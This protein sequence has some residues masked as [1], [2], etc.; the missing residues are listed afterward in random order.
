MILLPYFSVIQN[1]EA[2]Y[3]GGG[4]YGGFDYASMMGG[5]GGGIEGYIKDIGPALMRLPGCK[6]KLKKGA[7]AVEAVDGANN[8]GEQKGEGDGWGYLGDQEAEAGTQSMA[9]ATHDDAL[10]KKADKTLAN[11]DE[12]K[13][14]TVSTDTNKTCLDSIGKMVIKVMLQKITKSTVE[15]I[16]NGFEGNPSFITNAQKAYDAVTNDNLLELG[17]ELNDKM[18]HPYIGD[19]LKG[20]ATMLKNKFAQNAASSFNKLNPDTDEKR[21]LNDFTM[22]GWDAWSSITRPE[23]NPFGFQ[24]LASQEL[25]RR[26]EEGKQLLKE[27]LDRGHGFLSQEQCEDPKYLTREEDN[28]YLAGEYMV[29]DGTGHKIPDDSHHCKSWKEVTPGY[30]IADTLTTATK[31]PNNSLLDAQTLNDATAAILDALTSHFYNELYNKGLANTYGG[32]TGANYQAAYYNG[33][34]GSSSTQ[35]ELDYGNSISSSWLK[36]HPNFDIRTDLNQALIDDQRIYADNLELQN[37]ELNSQ[38]TTTAQ[39]TALNLPANYRGYYGL[40][41]IIHQLDYCIPGPHANWEE[42]AQALFDKKMATVVD[43][44]GMNFL[45]IGKSTDTPVDSGIAGIEFQG[46]SDLSTVFTVVNQLTQ[47]GLAT[48]ENTDLLYSADHDGV[49]LTKE[50]ARRY[51]QKMIKDIL[52]IDVARDINIDT[53][54]TTMNVFNTAFRG[55]RAVINN[56]FTADRMPVVTREAK[57]EFNKI[58]G[59]LEMKKNNEDKI[60]TQRGIVTR[61]Y[62]IKNAVDN[63]NAHLANSTLVLNPPNA[64]QQDEYEYELKP[65]ISSFGRLSLDLV[66][67]DDIAVANVVLKQI[68]DKEKYIYNDLLKGVTGCEKELISLTS[69]TS[70]VLPWPIINGKRVPYPLSLLPNNTYTGLYDYNLYTKPSILPDP[71]GMHFGALAPFSNQAVYNN[72]S[73]DRELSWAT[74]GSAMGGSGNFS[75]NGPNTNYLCGVI[76]GDANPGP[77]SCGNGADGPTIIHLTGLISPSENSAGNTVAK[78]AESLGIY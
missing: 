51:N 18:A 67:G 59:Y 73:N 69:G 6:N 42:D 74:F 17:N 13:K 41:P 61:L 11:T 58:T 46:S 49:T 52:G 34:S 12:I 57:T 10:N 20:Q 75:W 78:F 53:Y 40:V 36:N 62:T 50:T 68:K 23:N 24:L 39:A 5:G 19:F 3:S 66:D 28:A 56:I 55:L 72:Y 76:A 22:G 31:F 71:L 4:S 2:Q 32:T 25:Q 35:T 37:A 30:V 26:T 29:D 63:L 43:T 38:I 47:A 7:S 60:S 70:P 64:T 54:A 44:T 15:W 21:F 65:W 45:Q 9:V 1:A 27:Q 16:N 33:G 77:N 8:N 14:A 48:P